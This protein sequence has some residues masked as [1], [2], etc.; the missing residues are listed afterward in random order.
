M[1]IP[2][3]GRIVLLEI[4]KAPPKLPTIPIIAN[5][6]VLDQHIL[7]KTNRKSFDVEATYVKALRFGPWQGSAMDRPEL[8][9]SQREWDFQIAY[10]QTPE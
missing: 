4:R 1:R 10:L 5:D 7:E 9:H 6:T 3:P 2:P 8:R